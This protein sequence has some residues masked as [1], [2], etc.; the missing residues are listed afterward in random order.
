[1]DKN[2]SVG[3]GY[4]MSQ[5]TGGTFLIAPDGTVLKIDPTREEIE[6]VLAEI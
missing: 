3:A 6:A 1:M 5:R 4:G 2:H